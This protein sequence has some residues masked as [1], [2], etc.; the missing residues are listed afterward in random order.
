MTFFQQSF[1]RFFFAKAGGDEV[2]VIGPL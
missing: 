1:D 2:D